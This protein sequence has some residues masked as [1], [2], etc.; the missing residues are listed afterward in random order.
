MPNGH[1]ARVEM[2][3]RIQHANDEIYAAWNAHDPDAVIAWYAEEVEVVDITSGISAVGRD[4]IYATAIDRLTA[5]PD[6]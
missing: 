6:F 1:D 2:R 5:F 4:D 3:A